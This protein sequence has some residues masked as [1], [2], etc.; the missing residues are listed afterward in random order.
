MG[1]GGGPAF[2]QFFL[3]VCFCV[4]F[5]CFSDAEIGLVLVFVDA[6]ASTCLAMRI[7]RVLAVAEQFG[8]VAEIIGCSTE[9]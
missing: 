3:Y 5:A 4:I 1:T 8:S 6:A 7:F 9:N 2:C